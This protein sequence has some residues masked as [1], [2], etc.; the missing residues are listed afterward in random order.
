MIVGVGIDI[1]GD[2]DF[3]KRIDRS[4]SLLVSLL[5]LSHNLD[6]DTSH[7]DSNEKVSNPQTDIQRAKSNLVSIEAMFKAL[8]N[9]LRSNLDKLKISRDELGKPSIVYLGLNKEVFDQLIFHVSISHDSG[10]TI[11]IVIIES[12]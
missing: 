12:V 9:N 8:P 3:Q 2:I 6:V 7:T 11:G 10:V 1:I 5:R 4:P